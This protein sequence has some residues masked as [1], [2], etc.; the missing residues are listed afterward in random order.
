[1]AIGKIILN[2]IKVTPQ[3]VIAFFPSYTQLETFIDYWQVILK[4]IYIFF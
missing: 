3:G 1:M 2:T 4:I